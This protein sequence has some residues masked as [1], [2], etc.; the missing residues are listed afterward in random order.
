M[1]TINPDDLI[2]ATAAKS[3]RP[4]FRKE[5]AKLRERPK[6]TKLRIA[7][8]ADNSLR[9]L[10]SRC[11]NTAEGALRSAPG[12]MISVLLQKIWGLGLPVLR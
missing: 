10:W 7:T 6:R 11:E 2:C 12:G 1:T 3:W 4:H 8:T 9:R 5:R